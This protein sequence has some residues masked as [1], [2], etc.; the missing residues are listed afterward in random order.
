MRLFNDERGTCSCF[1]VAMDALLLGMLSACQMNSRKFGVGSLPPFPRAP[2]SVDA[3]LSLPSHAANSNQSRL[4]AYTF[5]VTSSSP[6]LPTPSNSTSNLPW[7]SSSRRWCAALNES[8]VRIPAIPLW[9]AV[10]LLR[11]TMTATR[12][13]TPRGYFPGS[14]EGAAE[15]VYT[16]M[17]ET[18]VQSTKVDLYSGEGYYEDGDD[19]DECRK[20]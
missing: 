10:I 16:E 7:R 6:Q 8:T 18:Q 13:G 17:A 14:T 19:A 12:C 2:P 1:P 20:P 4:N 5:A 15:L 9:L 11:T 3:V